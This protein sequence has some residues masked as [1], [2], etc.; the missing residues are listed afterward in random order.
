MQDFFDIQTW[1]PLTVH[2]PIAF[3]SLSGLLSI[4]LL[5]KFQKTIAQFNL[6]LLFL[7]VITALISLYTGD[8]E[9]GKV[10]RT[11][12]DPTIL[13]DHENFAYY[14]VYAFSACLVLWSVKLFA[15]YKK[16]K[17]LFISL[18]FILNLAGLAGLVYVGHL[19]ASLV[20]EQ[21]AGVDVPSEDCS[22]F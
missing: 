9:D 14:S 1:H 6:G 13:K 3:L 2:F 21:A 20:Y 19:G 5:F 16:F 4:Y 18:I 8:I 10:S 15:S 22:D 17:T 11:L 12:C 7:G